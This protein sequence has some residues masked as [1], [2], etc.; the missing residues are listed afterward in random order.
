M[1]AG[2]DDSE[3]TSDDTESDDTQSDDTEAD[4]TEADEDESA[5]TEADDDSASD[6]DV[7]GDGGCSVK[8]EGD[9]SASWANAATG[10]LL[11]GPW[12]DETAGGTAFDQDIFLMACNSADG[13]NAISFSSKQG[14]AVPM[15]AATYELTPGD[16]LMNG[17][18]ADDEIQVVVNLA[19]TETNWGLEE[20]G[21]FTTTEFTGDR[22]EGTFTMAIK[23][24][25][26]AA[27]GQP[28]KGS[29]VLTGQFA[30]TDDL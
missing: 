25:L 10:S 3:V 11:Y 4:D 19:G 8:V 13:G 7:S 15:E 30:F 28:S 27:G 20:P 14:F 9:V 24:V 5:D 17:Q 16:S 1:T 29:A 6:V 18:S 21:T 22:S 26:S 12:T 2:D 23:D